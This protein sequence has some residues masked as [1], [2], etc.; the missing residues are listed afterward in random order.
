MNKEMYRYAQVA[1]K[2]L[3]AIEAANELLIE[4]YNIR[5]DELPVE[6]FF[7][8]FAIETSEIVFG[9]IEYHL[10]ELTRVCP[11]REM[12]EHIYAIVQ[13]RPELPHKPSPRILRAFV[14][15]QRSAGVPVFDLVKSFFYA[16][17]GRVRNPMLWAWNDALE[18]IGSI[19][20]TKRVR[21]FTHARK[22]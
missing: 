1:A 9:E 22:R 18:A 8:Q 13:G 11:D 15:Q 7:E 12:R 4:L 10:N 5:V 20:T 16:H 14:K 6:T 21:P 17:R 19:N 3:L 2:R